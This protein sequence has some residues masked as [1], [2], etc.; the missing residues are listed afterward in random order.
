MVHGSRTW[1]VETPLS[2]VLASMPDS[3]CVGVEATIDCVTGSKD[4]TPPILHA[5]ILATMQ[6]LESGRV[7]ARDKKR[8]V[9]M[10][11][12]RHIDLC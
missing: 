9:P 1:E 6:R 3:I 11:S 7:V 8:C 2:R 10:L 4:G 12:E 5:E